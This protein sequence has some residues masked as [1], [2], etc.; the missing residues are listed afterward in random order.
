MITTLMIFVMAHNEIGQRA[1]LSLNTLDFYYVNEIDPDSYW[2]ASITQ[3]LRGLSRG[4][5]IS[6]TRWFSARDGLEIGFLSTSTELY[7]YERGTAS[8]NSIEFYGWSYA[9][10]ARYTNVSLSLIWKHAFSDSGQGIPIQ[11]EGLFSGACC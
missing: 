6:Y 8:L 9:L 10:T 2:T 1:Q 11:L 7:G 5:A 3:Q 4:G